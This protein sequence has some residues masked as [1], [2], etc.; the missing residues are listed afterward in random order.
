MESFNILVIKVVFFLLRLNFRKKHVYWASRLKP[1][2]KMG[3]IAKRSLLTKG[4]F[5]TRQTR[6]SWDFKGPLVAVCWWEFTSYLGPV[7]CLWDFLEFMCWMLVMRNTLLIFRPLIAAKLF[8]C[9]YL[10]N[11]NLVHKL[12]KN[13]AVLLLTDYWYILINT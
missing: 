11:V 12:T 13:N 9:C 3:K 4:R 1:G 8:F 7:G 6:T 5:V 2:N 10:C